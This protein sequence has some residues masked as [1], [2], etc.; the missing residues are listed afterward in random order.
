M[1]EGRQIEDR[2]TAVSERDSGLGFVPAPVI[3][4]T[5]M[6]HDRAHLA[7]DPARRLG[8]SWLRPVPCYPAHIV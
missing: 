8:C 7:D 3:V 4:W 5:A 6:T 1:P 2:K